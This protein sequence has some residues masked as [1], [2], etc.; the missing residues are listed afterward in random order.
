MTIS[1]SDFKLPPINLWVMPMVTT[2]KSTG[3]ESY[4]D[5]YLAVVKD[6]YEHLRRNLDRQL[7]MINREQKRRKRLANQESC[8]MV[9]VY[10]KED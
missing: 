10:S 4:D 5:E 6:R 2:K 1:W 3:F 8:D 9:E 7:A